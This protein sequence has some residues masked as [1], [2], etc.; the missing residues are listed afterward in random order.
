MFGKWGLFVLATLASAAVLTSSAGAVTQGSAGV[1][2]STRAGVVS[3]SGLARGQ[4]HA[5]SS[6]SAVRTT[7]RARI[8]RVRA[9][10]ARP[11]SACCRSRR[12]KNDDNN[13]VCAG[14]SGTPPGTAR[15]SSSRTAARQRRPMRRAVQRCVCESGLRDHAVQH[16]R[17]QQRPDPAAGRCKGR[18]DAG[19]RRSTAGAPDHNGSGTNDVQINQDLKQSVKK[20]TD[21]AGRRPRTAIRTRR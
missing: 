14:G 8:A 6:S 20:N 13:F 4:S 17:Q 16:R 11:R 18:R 21:A 9:G 2:V 19:S 10:P 5:E 7:T 15:S 12:R 3:I 1:N